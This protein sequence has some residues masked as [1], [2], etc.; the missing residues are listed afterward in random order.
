[1]PSTRRTDKSSKEVEESNGKGEYH[2]G[3]RPSSAVSLVAELR[4][5]YFCWDKLTTRGYLETRTGLFP[6]TS[7][8]PLD[9]RRRKYTC[10]T[11]DED[12]SHQLPNLRPLLKPAPKRTGSTRPPKVPSLLKRARVRLETNRWTMGK[13]KEEKDKEKGLCRPQ[14][15]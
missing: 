3:L 2:L 4:T 15:P 6:G 1:M 10:S 8:E 13:E 9:A 12:R 14:R 7:V 5:K 11:A